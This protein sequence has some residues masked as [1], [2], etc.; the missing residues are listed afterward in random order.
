MIEE[1]VPESDS[2]HPQQSLEPGPF[3]QSFTTSTLTDALLDFV[4]AF[5]S[6]YFLAFAILA[7]RRDQS[8]VEGSRINNALLEAA[9]YV[10]RLL[11]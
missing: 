6:G 7:W 10:S 5:S 4:V 2:E 11:P 1:L 8:P 3:R 9:R